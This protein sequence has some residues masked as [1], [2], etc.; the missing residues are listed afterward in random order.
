MASTKKLAQRADKAK[1]S[2]MQRHVLVCT[3]SDCKGG[4]AV[5]K[6]IKKGVAAARLR[7]EVST[8]KVECLS[9]CK[10]GGAVVVVYPEGTWYGGVDVDVADR[11]V[12]EHLIGGTPLSDEAFLINPLGCAARL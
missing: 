12:S 6:R 7:A 4:S 2:T 5:A 3:D 8:S 1:L 11:I 10:G 9:I